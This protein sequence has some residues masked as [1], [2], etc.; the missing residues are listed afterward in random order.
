MFLET[1][2]PRWIAYDMLAKVIVRAVTAAE[3]L[4]GRPVERAVVTGHSK[5][6][7]ASLVA[8]A[9][10]DRIVGAMPSGWFAGN[11]PEFI[12]HKLERWGPDYMPFP[13]D[14]KGPAYVTTAEQAEWFTRPGYDEYNRYTDPY[15]FRDLYRGKKVLNTIGTN[16]PLYPVTSGEAFLPEMRDVGVAQLYAPNMAHGNG[17]NSHRK[18]WAM[19]LAHVL[20]GRAIPRVKVEVAREAGGVRI[21]ARPETPHDLQKIRVFGT[22]DDSGAYLGATWKPIAMR[23]RLADDSYEAFIPLSAGQHAVGFVEVQDQD[24]RGVPGVATSELFEIR[25]R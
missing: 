8:C 9:V 3:A 14:P 18:A 7:L 15:M 6:G 1:R 13:G 12:E 2:D 11:G 5:R 20:R 23:R 22:V 21:T 16:D 24:P 25:P 19:W 17:S 4:G 10:D